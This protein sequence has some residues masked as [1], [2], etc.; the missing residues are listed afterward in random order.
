M[1][2]VLLRTT[3]RGKLMQS[4]I[5]VWGN[6]EFTYAG[7][8][9]NIILTDLSFNTNDCVSGSMSFSKHECVK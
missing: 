5:V 7:A 3:Y 1:L 9:G 8:K 2:T 4:S 6:Q